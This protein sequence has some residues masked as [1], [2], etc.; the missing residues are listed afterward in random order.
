M[1]NIK[2]SEMTEATSFDDGDYTMIIQANQNKKIA[3][4]NIFSNLENE[5]TANAN[6][7][8]TINNNIGDLSDLETEDKSSVVNSINELKNTTTLWEGA[9]FPAGKTYTLTDN[10]YNYRFAIVEGQWGNKFVI[11]IIPGNTYFNGGMN[12]PLGNGTAMATTGLNASIVN[13]GLGISV[14][15]FR[16]LTHNQ[17][18][19]HGG[20]E[21]PQLY[22][23]IGIK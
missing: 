9:E 12:Y 3:K 23:I 22:K 10:I 17:N 15:Y 16:Q 1:A 5:I 19:N 2:V 18:S 6:G 21:S 11:P 13:D 14:T 8:S 20:F 4:E 7:I